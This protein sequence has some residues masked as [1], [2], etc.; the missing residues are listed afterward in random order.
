MS[1]SVRQFLRERQALLV[2]LNTPMSD[3]ATGFPDDLRQ[4]A[5]LKDVPLSFST[6]QVSDHGPHHVPLREANAGGS[7]GMVVDIRDFDSVV[8][9]GAGDDGTDFLPDNTVQSGGSPPSACACARSIN[10][11]I[12]P[13]GVKEDRS[14][15]W[16]VKNYLPIGI[17]VFDST[18]VFI[19]GAGERPCSLDEVLNAFSSDRIFGTNGTSFTEW[20]R[21]SKTWNPVTYEDIVATGPS[22][23]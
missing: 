20:D 9:V 1:F 23:L 10:N 6:I 13:T 16:F 11:R 8:T 4:A 7:V 5:T 19:A 14:N 18:H 22:Q 2:H 21:T 3:H 12:D 15:E 17:F